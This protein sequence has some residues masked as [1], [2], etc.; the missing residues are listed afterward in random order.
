MIIFAPNYNLPKPQRIYI[1]SKTTSEQICNDMNLSNSFTFKLLHWFLNK[2]GYSPR[3]GSYLISPNSNNYQ[4][5]HKLYGG[6]QNP[7]SLCIGSHDT[8]ELLCRYLSTKMMFS[9]EEIFNVINDDSYMKRFDVDSNTCTTIFIPNTYEVY[10]TTSPQAFIQRIYDEYTRFWNST[11][12][13]KAKDMGLSPTQVIILASIVQ[14]E[15]YDND[16]IYAPQIAGVYM[17]RL[18]RHMRLQ[19]DPTIKYIIQYCIKLNETAT[20]ADIAKYKRVQSPYNTYVNYGLPIGNI[21]IPS[22]EVI[23]AVLN[24]EKNDYLYFFYYHFSKTYDEHLKTI[25]RLRRN[26]KHVQNTRR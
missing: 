19:A 5:I 6:L 12:L 26:K 23:D 2:F 9:Y 21:T 16:N 18:R 17:N 11:R 10:W 25:R 14:K 22:I 8:K 7:I 20:F 3:V 4:I 24:Y 1:T 13:S 15:I